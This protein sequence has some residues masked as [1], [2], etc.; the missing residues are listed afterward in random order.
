MTTPVKFCRPFRPGPVAEKP[1]IESP[2]LGLLR[3]G[4][5]QVTEWRRLAGRMPPLDAHAT[6]T[7]QSSSGIYRLHVFE[8]ISV[9]VCECFEE[10]FRMPTRQ[11]TG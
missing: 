4:R 9:D 2:T 5:R 11:T 7:I 1:T 8:C 3:E 6:L 10:C